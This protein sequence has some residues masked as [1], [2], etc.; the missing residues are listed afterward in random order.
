MA[1]TTE[2]KKLIDQLQPTPGYVLIEPEEQQKQTA[3]GI[4]LPETASADKP[5][6]GK[7][8]VVGSSLFM[9]NREVVAP[10]KKG[11]KVIYKK[12]GGNEV[13]LDNKE[14]LLVKFEDILAVIA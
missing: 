14:Y 6:M 3:S 12:W 7:V 1:K 9:D 4:Y 8:L 2:P 10:A 5:Q 13:K 11:D